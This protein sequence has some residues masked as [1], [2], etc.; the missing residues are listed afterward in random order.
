MTWGIP[1]DLFLKVHVALSL[2]GI[3]SGLIALLGM[4]RGR[5]LAGWAAL[6]LA[7]T[8][9]TSVTG[10]PLPPL[11]L[12]PARILGIISLI[13]LAVAIAALYLFRLAGPLRWIYVI[14]A[15][16]ALFF[17]AFVGVVQSFDKISSLHAIG[18]AQD[19]PAVHIAQ[20][21]LL[22]LLIVLG[23]VAVLRFRPGKPPSDKP[24]RGISTQ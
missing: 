18:P 14:A 16:A 22:A 11:G 4:V 6:F 1:T 9:L 24:Q 8:V 13:V 3:A 15:T 23:I 20:L 17:N 21:A 12:D 10:F 5:L 2:I 7:A 19:A